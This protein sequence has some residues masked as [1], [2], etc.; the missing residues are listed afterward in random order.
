MY[1]VDGKMYEFGGF[2]IDYLLGNNLLLKLDLQT[3]TWRCLS[4]TV[5]LKP[6]PSCPGFPPAASSWVDHERRKIFF[7]GGE[8]DIKLTKSDGKFLGNHYSYVYS[9]LN[10]P[11]AR[12]EMGW[13]YNP[14]LKRLIVFNGF[15]S[16]APLQRSTR[17]KNIDNVCSYFTDTY[18]FDP[19]AFAWKHVFT[20]GFPTYRALGEMFSDPGVAKV[21][22]FR[23]Y[24]DN[25]IVPPRIGFTSAFHDIWQLRL[26]MEGGLWDVVDLEE[27]LKMAKAG[28][29]QRCF[30]CSASGDT[31]KMKKCQAQGWKNN[32]F[33]FSS[34]PQVL[35]AVMN[36]LNRPPLFIQ[37]LF[38]TQ[39]HATCSAMVIAPLS[40][41]YCVSLS[42]PQAR[43]NCVVCK[44][45]VKHVDLA[46]RWLKARWAAGDVFRLS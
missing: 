19:A 18:I 10:P 37:A 42:P 25:E 8:A 38:E 5:Q 30:N 45:H 41:R 32:V 40:S 21:F 17:L 13:D 20:R 7:M 28:P 26:D 31:K 44:A 29:W 2:S 22:L 11:G 39:S 33:N 6:D 46:S 35:L 23:G 34:Y 14:K 24:T 9:D 27:D 36:V 43:R 15:S 3:K 16:N 12:T 1:I 4:G